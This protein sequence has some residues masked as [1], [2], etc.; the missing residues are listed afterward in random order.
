M[1]IEIIDK[2]DNYEE[3]IKMSCDILEEKWSGRK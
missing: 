3:A 1:F 2:V